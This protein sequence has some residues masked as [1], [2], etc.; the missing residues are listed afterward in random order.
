MYRNV[1]SLFFVCAKIHN[2]K[3]QVTSSSSF[4]RLLI[5]F[6]IFLFIFKTAAIN[7]QY[8]NCTL[9]PTSVYP[10]RPERALPPTVPLPRQRQHL[11]PP[12]PTVGFRPRARPI[13][14]FPGQ[15]GRLAHT[16]KTGQRRRWIGPDTGPGRHC[17]SV[18]TGPPA[19]ATLNMAGPPS[20][21]PWSRPPARYSKC[22]DA[23]AASKP[24]LASLH[25]HLALRCA[26]LTTLPSTTHSNTQYR[27]YYTNHSSFASFPSAHPHTLFARS[28]L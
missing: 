20:C 27:V 24:S 17:F 23:P 16:Q 13:P 18:L 8:P 19:M 5:I 7:F 15:A 6:F 25:P 3:S 12:P 22:L 10:Y 28:T 1:P 21:Q 9:L 26:S 2:F 4:L 11:R 14:S